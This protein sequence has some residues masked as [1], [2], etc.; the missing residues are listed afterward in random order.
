MT[1]YRRIACSGNESDRHHWVGDAFRK[2]I[3]LYADDLKVVGILNSGTDSNRPADGVFS[4]CWL[5][6]ARCLCAMRFTSIDI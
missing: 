5:S 3:P 2:E 1:L 6:G 4:T